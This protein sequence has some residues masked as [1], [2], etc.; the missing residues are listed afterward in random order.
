MNPG[1]VRPALTPGFVPLRTYRVTGR[2]GGDPVPLW[3]TLAGTQ[4]DRP[5][6][7]GSKPGFEGLTFAGTSD[8]VKV[9]SRF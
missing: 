2:L 5:V 8:N 7:T 9:R 3:G 4:L 6:G 1:E